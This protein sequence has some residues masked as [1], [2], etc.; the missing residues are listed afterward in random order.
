LS[1]AVSIVCYKPDDA[2]CVEIEEVIFR[3]VLRPWEDELEVETRT[4]CKEEGLQAVNFGSE[5]G[6]IE[7]ASDDDHL[8]CCVLSRVTEAKNI[9]LDYR[10]RSRVALL[11]CRINEQVPIL[12]NRVRK[13][14]IEVLDG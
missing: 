5:Q 9:E 14:L 11:Q 3:K 7:A 8:E 2:P 13:R 1:E 6:V 4:V 10:L 12:S